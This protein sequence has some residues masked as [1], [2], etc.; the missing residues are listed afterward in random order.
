[1]KP[2]YILLLALGIGTWAS[3]RADTAADVQRLLTSGQ[4]LA[5]QTS[6]EAALKTKP[7]DPE[8]RFLLGVV[9]TDLM[10][11]QEALQVFTDLS[12]EF[13][14]LPDPLNNLAVLHA[15][16]GDLDAARAALE[17]AL[18]KN[19]RHR[20]A[21]ENLGDVYLRLALKQWQSAAD[22]SAPEPLLAQKL[23]LGRSLVRQLAMPPKT[24]SH[25]PKP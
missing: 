12:Q 25:A 15:S 6:L 5:A 13:P 19:P 7:K 23:S 8:L 24:S 22:L 18:R 1:M 11:P 20:A 4:L 10:K 21:Q 17:L 3:V 16:R 2:I 14:E 9:L